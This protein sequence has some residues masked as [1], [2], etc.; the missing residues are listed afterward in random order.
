RLLHRCT[1]VLEASSHFP[2][3]FFERAVKAER[4]C[5]GGTKPCIRSIPFRR[6]IEYLARPLHNFQ[7]A[8][9]YW[10]ASLGIISKILLRHGACNQ[11]SG[12]KQNGEHDCET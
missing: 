7:I 11:R 3:G 1:A 8:F 12:K 9:G 4:L 10:R 6:I 5:V 2:G